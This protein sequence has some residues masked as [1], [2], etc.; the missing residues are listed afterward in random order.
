[1]L[2]DPS[3]LERC[4]RSD[5]SKEKA[6]SYSC[7][8]T[9]CRIMS[10]LQFS[11]LATSSRVSSCRGLLTSYFLCHPR[12]HDSAC[13]WMSPPV[14][15]RLLH[16]LCHL[17]AP[18]AASVLQAGL[19][20]SFLRFRHGKHFHDVTAPHVASNLPN[21]L[22]FNL[23][24]HAISCPIM[25]FHVVFPCHLVPLRHLSGCLLGHLV[26]RHGS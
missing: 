16:P 8:L 17:M 4:P 12:C 22:P 20:L 18:L 10:F 11:S 24:S 23:M 26:L 25:S 3:Q 19:I 13:L 14:T 6:G 2:K 15:T 5:S 7:P 1:M 21:A 9:F